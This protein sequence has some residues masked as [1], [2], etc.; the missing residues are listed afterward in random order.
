LLSLRNIKK[1][2]ESPGTYSEK[3][4]LILIAQN[5][6]QAFKIIYDLYQNRIYKQALYLTKDHVVAEDA[7]QEIFV[8]LWVNRTKLVEVNDLQAYLSVLTKNHIYNYFRKLNYHEKYIGHFLANAE[9]GSRT[10]SETINYN[11][12]HH[13]IN[14][15]VSHLPS[16]QRRVYELSRSE[17]LKFKDIA[18]RLNI[19]GETVKKHLS[20]AL[21][22]IKLQLKD[23]KYL[24]LLYLF[25]S[26]KR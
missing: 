17:G 2:L 8:K 22:K 23:Y 25:P 10:T 3:E 5:N 11:D 18:K 9:I 7:I 21:R 14:L 4:L 13:R 12:L 6:E 26:K 16:Q 1:D 20:E 19:S 24:I 15:A